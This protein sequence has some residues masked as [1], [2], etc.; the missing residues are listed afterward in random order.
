MLLPKLFT[1]LSPGY[2]VPSQDF[3][4]KCKTCHKIALQRRW[5]TT[6]TF[7]AFVSYQCTVHRPTSSPADK[8]TASWMRRSRP[9][10]ECTRG[11]IA[12][13]LNKVLCWCNSPLSGLKNKTCIQF[14]VNPRSRSRGGT[15]RVVGWGAS[16]HRH[17]WRTII[18]SCAQKSRVPGVPSPVTLAHP[19]DS[20][21]LS[22]KKG[23]PA[24][25]VGKASENVLRGALKP[26][27][28]GQQEPRD[29]GDGPTRLSEGPTAG[30]I[31]Y[32][33]QQRLNGSSSSTSAC[34]KWPNFSSCPQAAP[35]MSQTNTNHWK[36]SRYGISVLTM[37]PQQADEW[38][39]ELNPLQE[40]GYREYFSGGRNVFCI[41]TTNFEQF[42][43]ANFCFWPTHTCD[44][45]PSRV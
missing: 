5:W 44:K 23:T 13:Q 27:F 33:K 2:A 19:L 22:R 42:P 10:F 29:S 36:Q 16:K 28:T 39:L 3:V 9:S 37:Q 24:P 41:E 14:P 8:R 31:C 20:E 34:L 32:T 1:D 15:P 43:Q 38:Q 18:S 35:A 21:L 11:H 17:V 4:L 30:Q 40:L 45:T 7:K 12:S 26:N 25:M 6:E